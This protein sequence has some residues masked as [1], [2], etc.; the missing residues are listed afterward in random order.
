MNARNILSA[1]RSSS[2]PPASSPST[3]LKA[4]SGGT[5]PP[6]KFSGRALSLSTIAAAWHKPG[7]RLRTFT[8]TVLSGCA[9]LALGSRAHALEPEDVLYFHYGPLTLRPQFATSE[10]YDDNLF[11]THTNTVAD[12]TTVLSPG[13]KVQLG[14]PEENY[15]GIS[16][17]MDQ[18]FYADRTDLN[19]QQH[20]IDIQDQFKGAHLSLNGVDRIQLL[21]SPLGGV[22][23]RV[24]PG[25]L[26]TVTGQN[27]DRLGFDDAYTLTY[28][29]SEKAAI[30]ARAT[31]YSIDYLDN[32]ALYDLQTLTGT[33]GFAYR[34][35]PKTYFFGEMY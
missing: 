21:S 2:A 28:N 5:S 6:K 31:H 3:Y 19:T 12:F 30:Y 10:V 17:S 35:L 25:G 8:T 1:M 15:V 18:L 27:I 9:L 32:I 34:A 16:Y 14:R 26:A 4:R 29:V 33:G 22:V 24:G 20:T 11:Y 13:I 7:N 23:E